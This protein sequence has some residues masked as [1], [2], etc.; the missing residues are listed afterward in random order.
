MQITIDDLGVQVRSDTWLIFR[1]AVHPRTGAEVMLG[2]LARGGFMVIDPMAESGVQIRLPR[3]SVG[4][5]IAQAPDGSVWQ[6][7]YGGEGQCAALCRWNWDG[8]ASEVQVDLPEHGYF[9]ID[10]A[11]DGRVYAPHYGGNILYCYDPQTGQLASLGTFE[12]FGTHIH[13]VCCAPD[14]WIYVT[15]SDYVDHC[16]V[17][18][19]PRSGARGKLEPV[20]G[21]AVSPPY[22]QIR[23]TG[24]GMVVTCE[25]KWGRECWL[26]CIAGKAVPVCAA[27]VQLATTEISYSDTGIVSGITSLAFRDGS[28]IKA[29]D[30]KNITYVTA[31]GEART[32]KVLRE[33]SPVRIFSLESGGGRL[34]GGTFIPLTLFSHDTATREV[35]FYDNPTETTGEIYS[36]VW[37]NGKLFMASYTGATLTRFDP[38]R[39]FRMDH[40]TAANP[41]HLGLMKEEGLPLQRPYGKARAPDGTVFFAAHDG[42]GCIDSGICRI[43]PDTEEVVRWIYPATDFDALCYLSDPDLLLVGERRNGEDGVRFTFVSPDDGRVVHSETV[44]H[45]EGN[46]TSWLPDEADPRLVHGMYAYRGAVFTYDLVEHQIIRQLAE[47]DQ[48]GLCYNMLLFGPDDR[49]WGYSD[50]CVFAVERDLSAV[51]TLAAYEDHAGGNCYRFGMVYG[52]AGD[53]YFPNGPQLMRVRWGLAQDANGR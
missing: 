6:C 34:W 52:L 40:S 47:I 9:S 4:W 36:A 32:F 35:T 46:V 38:S 39:P 11:P 2:S 23:R 33:E 30:R 5:G 7:A 16:V 17:A 26:E 41:A 48:G 14:G 28:Y 21:A 37:S 45:D 12:E 50:R 8:S 22:S 49:I 31:T 43:D 20:D 15:A 27:E 29:V 44:I 19:D 42:Y 13:D 18:I 10:V 51:E 24:A 3:P 25:A 53:I 1:H